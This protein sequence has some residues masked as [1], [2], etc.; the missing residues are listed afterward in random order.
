MKILQIIRCLDI[1][2]VGGG[3]ELFAIRLSRALQNQQDTDVSIC[4]FYRVG[5]KEEKIWAETLNLEGIKTF[6]A[7][8]K[9]RSLDLINI[10]KGFEAIEKF[11]TD[12]KIDVVQSHSYLGSV[13]SGL[14]KL[15]K[16]CKRAFR[17][18]HI[19]NESS[20]SPYHIF[21]KTFLVN[22]FFPLT[23]DG[24]I[25]V[26]K[27]ILNELEGR[28]LSRL[29][30]GSIKIHYLPNGI[31]LN[32]IPGI[33]ALN[34]E[35]KSSRNGLNITSIGRLSEQKGFTYLVNA[36][37]QLE[38]IIPQVRLEI[39]GDGEGRRDLEKLINDLELDSKV[40]LIGQLPQDSVLEKLAQ[41]HLFV[42]SSLWEG[43][44]TVVLEAMATKTPVIATDIPGTRELISNGISGWLVPP[45]NA[46]SLAEAIIYAYLNPLE[47]EKLAKNAYA[48]L[49]QYDIN[50][51]ARDYYGL[52]LNH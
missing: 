40:K 41:S 35:M 34:N 50:Q 6:F 10:W 7:T 44:P 20:I 13:T 39:I 19:N 5:S 14:L 17:T 18:V 43:L 51:I 2:Q 12:E 48:N 33:S 23:L 31:D 37:K 4:S 36:M 30:K 21:I 46:K 1:G 42:L 29:N 32:S 24:E 15:S 8:D 16:K 27:S 45:K 38:K 49:T 3:A 47:G 52:Y 28:F 25:G 9:K 11:V 22:M 26:S